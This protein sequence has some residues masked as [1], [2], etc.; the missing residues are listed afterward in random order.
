MT[1]RQANQA[2]KEAANNG[3][4]TYIP[5]PTGYGIRVHRAR[6]KNGICQARAISSGVWFDLDSFST[7]YHQ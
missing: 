5:S 3:K 7:I 1:S 4:N 2:I 6:V